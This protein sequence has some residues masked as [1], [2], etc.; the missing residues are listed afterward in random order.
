MIHFKLLNPHIIEKVTKAIEEVAREN[1]YTYVLDTSEGSMV[2]FS[3]DN[4]VDITEK[5]KA[6]M[7]PAK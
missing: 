6:K 4:A 5:V 1:G 2:I 3:A 7:T